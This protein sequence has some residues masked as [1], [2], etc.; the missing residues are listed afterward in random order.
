MKHIHKL[1]LL[2]LSRNKEKPYPVYICRLEGC[3][4]FFRLEMTIGKLTLCWACKKPT[5]ILKRHIHRK[6]KRIVCE[7]C[8]VKLY[9]TSKKPV[10]QEPEFDFENFVSKLGVQ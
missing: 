9:P 7:D 5:E 10:S 6:T 1:E 4:S 8:K 3:S 2:N